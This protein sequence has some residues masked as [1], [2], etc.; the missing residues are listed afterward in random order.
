MNDLKFSKNIAA[1]G[2]TKGLLSRIKNII[3]DS[4]LSIPSGSSKNLFRNYPEKKG[5]PDVLKLESRKAK[6]MAIGRKDSEA[7]RPLHQKLSEAFDLVFVHERDF[8]RPEGAIQ[9]FYR[10]GY[11]AIL[12]PNPYGNS[13]RLAIYRMARACGIQTVVFDRGAL[14][15]AWFFDTGFNAESRSY[16]ISVWD[17]PLSDYETSRTETYVEKLRTGMCTLEEQ[18]S[19]SSVGK[20]HEKYGLQ[21]RKILFAPLQRPA[22][23]VIKFFAGNIH[24]YKDFLE[25]LETLQVT[26]ERDGEWSLLCKKHPLETT[27]DSD[28]LPMTDASENVHALLD[29]ADA[30]VCVNSGVG[31]LSILHDTPVYHFG[32]TFYSHPKLTRQV[33]SHAELHYNLCREL[34]TVDRDTR[35]RLCFH[36]RERVY[37]FGTLRTEIVTKKNGDRYRRTNA[38]DFYSLR[39]PKIKKVNKGSYRCLF[40]TPVVPAPLNRGSVARTQQMLDSLISAGCSVDLHILNMSYAEKTRLDIKLDVR[41]RFPAVRNI[42]VDHHPRLNRPNTAIKRFLLQLPDQLRQQIARWRG[43]RYS[44]GNARDLPTNFLL[45]SRSFRRPYP[46]PYDVIWFNYAKMVTPTLCRLGH[47]AIVDTHDVQLHRIHNDVLFPHPARKKA[48]FLR[49]IETSERSRLTLCDRIIA[50]SSLDEKFFSEQWNLAK[51]TVTINAALSDRTIRQSVPYTSDAIFVGSA[52]IA[53]ITSLCWFIRSVAPIIDEITNQPIII[54]IIGKVASAKEIVALVGSNRLKNVDIRLEGFVPSLN[55]V[56]ASSAAVIAPIVQGSGM[57]IKVIEALAHRK[58]V[59]G[60]PT[61]FDGI[62]IQ[63]GVSAMVAEDKSTFSTALIDVLTTKTLRINLEANGYAVFERDHSQAMSDRAVAG[64][65][66][67]LF[68]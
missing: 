49:R 40:V 61:A 66:H 16:D 22:D 63:H 37:S 38:I 51:K 29:S 20:I 60:T 62:R 13:M 18:G 43:H 25:H 24:S 11:D 41:K 9:Q 44:I 3:N 2:K 57:K 68:D 32:R 8:H 67:T 35:N 19:K 46:K 36:L 28:I 14:P 52:S 26:L 53:N 10:S 33:Q 64:M 6:L 58:A 4:K 7:Y 23:S 50:I 59:I 47:K 5:R 15:D 1:Q 31:L 12:F 48:E 45:R 55:A 65:L 27:I 34:L 17:H 21:G 39:L 54:R 30:V 42:V 56:Y